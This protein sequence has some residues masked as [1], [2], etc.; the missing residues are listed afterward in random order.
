MFQVTAIDV[1]S[2]ENG[3][4]SYSITNGNADEHFEID[5]N[6]GFIKVA[7]KIDR[8]KMERYIVEVTARDG[9]EPS[10]TR[11]VLVNIIV[12]DVNDNPPKFAQENYTAI[13]QVIRLFKQII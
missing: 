9:G 6:T 4:V 7:A 3:K 2:R 5:S 1:D 11:S 8:E 10:L 12:L 13:V